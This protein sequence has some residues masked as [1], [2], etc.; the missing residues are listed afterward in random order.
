[1]RA[2][3]GVVVYGIYLL[4]F[5]EYYLL[6]KLQ[7]TQLAS[8]CCLCH[9]VYTPY[10]YPLLVSY[11]EVL[12]PFVDCSL[13]FIRRNLILCF[14][15]LR[16]LHNF[17]AIMKYS[18]AFLFLLTTRSLASVPSVTSVTLK[19]ERSSNFLGTIKT[20]SDPTTYKIHPLLRLEDASKMP[21]VMWW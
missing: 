10:P 14:S 3:Y 21:R 13:F 19:A 8:G 6:Q 9:V 5:T 16:H 2:L 12:P 15:F 11:S 1:M 17:F 18:L 7:S 4:L 20:K